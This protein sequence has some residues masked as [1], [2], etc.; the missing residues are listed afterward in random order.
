[1]NYILH[2]NAVMKSFSEDFRLNPT[3]ISLYMALFQF[4]NHNHFSKVIYINREEVMKMSKI[5]SMSTYHKCLKQLHKWDYIHYIPT[6]NPFKNSQIKFVKFETSCGTTT[7]TSSGKSSG[8][9]DVRVVEKAPVSKIKQLKQTENNLKRPQ[10]K[11]EVINFFKEKKWS[12]F[13]AEKFYCHYEAVGWKMGGKIEIFNWQAVAEKWVLRT[14]E[15]EI[16]SGLTKTGV[17]VDNLQ[18]KKKKN[19][20]KPL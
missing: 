17:R 12:L 9:T 20:G 7:G 3:H 1:M 4:W 15:L 13:E 5:G 14:D 18:I 16:R 8:E 11:H 6:H 2:L 10:S 19:Y